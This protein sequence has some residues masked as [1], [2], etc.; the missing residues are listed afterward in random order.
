M[1]HGVW[2]NES[3]LFGLR[4]YFP[5]NIMIIS[6]RGGFILWSGR[7]AW[8]PVDFSTGTPRYSICDV[9]QWFAEIVT[10]INKIHADYGIT[11]DNIF[12]M[13]FSQGAIMSYY[14]LYHAPEKI[15]G[16]IALSGRI[17]D[18]LSK[19]SAIDKEKY[20]TK[21]VFIGHGTEDRVIPLSAS[22]IAAHFI[23]SLD[24][25]PVIKLYHEPHTITSPE[26][27]DIIQWLG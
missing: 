19:Q 1:L 14:T 26:I 8:Y 2:S 6:L 17:L 18:E 22:E 11:Y 12:L 7:H 15:G 3:D 16:I 25:I 9:E 23:E 21:R 5:E 13:G 24:I 20:L 4:E 10:C 27:H